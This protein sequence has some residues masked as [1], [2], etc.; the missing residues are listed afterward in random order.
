[1]PVA[2]VLAAI[3]TWGPFGAALAATGV[4]AN[5]WVSFA[6]RTA[7]G[8]GLKALSGSAA[9]VGGGAGAAR[10]YALGGVSGAALDHQIIYGRIKVGGARVY[11]ATTGEDNKFLHRI[12][13][14]AGHRIDQ[15]EDIYLNDE[16]VAK[17]LEDAHVYRFL[18]RVSETDSKGRTR[19]FW[20]SDKRVLAL[21]EIPENQ[22]SAGDYFDAPTI[23]KFLLPLAASLNVTGVRILSRVRNRETHVAAGRFKGLVRI[24]RYDGTTGQVA[25]AELID[26]TRNL[27]VQEGR[28]SNAHRL[29]GIAYL[30]VRL[31]F[32]DD[33]YP[34]GVPAISATIRGRLVHD[35]RTDT[36]AWSDNPA[37]CIRD[38]LC[39]DFGLNVPAS[40]IDDASFIAA[41]NICDQMVSGEK[42]Y[43][44]NG[45]FLTSETPENVLSAM[46]TSMGGI[47]WFSRGK[48]RVKAAA[49]S[50]PVAT[51]DE[52]DL[53]SGIQ[54]MTRSSR[55]DTFNTVKGIFSGDETDWQETD[56]PSV[57]RSTFV[58]TDGGQVNALD[59]PLPFTKT[60]SMCQRLALIALFRNREQLTFTA[61]FSTR[62]M[63]LTIGD[64]IRINN[65]RF[66]WVNKPFEI[67]S[68]QFRYEDSGELLV[69]MSL[70]EISQA[71]FESV[72]GSIFER[73]NTRLPSPFSVGP[74]AIEL[75][76]ELRVVN[77][78]VNGV[79]IAEVTAEDTNL[80]MVQVQFKKSANSIWMPV[81][82]GNPGIFE[83]LNIEDGL[84][85]VRAR[86]VNG[87]GVRGDWVYVSNFQAA[88]FAPP[89]QNVTN[90][91]GNVVGN[92]LHLTWNAVPDLDLSH[93]RIRYST[94]T[95]GALYRDAT[96][97][98]RRVARPAVSTTVPARAGTY[99][100]K[101]YDKLGTPSGASA[102]IVVRTDA[103][104]LQNLNLVS[105]LTEHDAFSGAK[106]NTVR[107]AAGT[108]Y[109]TLASGQT[110]GTY[111]FNG[112]VDLGAKYTSRAQVNANIL[113]LDLTSNFDDAPGLFDDREGLFDGDA[114]A[115][116]GTTSV[117]SQISITDDNPSG[118]PVWSDWQDFVVGDVAARA[119]RFR[120]VLESENTAHAPGVQEL[121]AVVDM[122]DRVESQQDLT[123]S[124]S[125]VLNVTFPVPF[126]EAPA[127]GLTAVLADGDRYVIT[128]RTRTGFTVTIYTG[129]VVST[130]GATVDYIAKGYG[131]G[132]A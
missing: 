64:I 87:L 10:G 88:P 119:I 83:L 54:L 75:S 81:Q 132:L 98:V 65:T 118:S 117:R 15:F 97:L 72:G 12:M 68:W 48:W 53:R 99:F 27:S 92:T 11:D 130:K 115:E 106:S 57:T 56:Y 127:I 69:D 49:W 91:A 18:Y 47:L 61:S 82:A 94:K 79:L 25:D 116:I 93:Y 3:A 128:G 86:G 28:W 114:N 73:N 107:I 89:P 52:D 41:A 1:M 16:A 38:Y 4:F 77:E 110:S 40:R 104:E 95:S 85:D 31:E 19:R 60:A 105:T 78:Q 63:T 122:P 113:F 36:T 96:D 6:V 50:E 111:T 13:A 124:S 9:R 58:T 43:T 51:F 35:P 42:R 84:Y 125:G 112:V 108:P 70:R 26:D 23:T 44:L 37:L 74:V 8:L 20:E 33:A 22:Y 67:V 76:D 24:R 66:G 121:T 100:I 14:F 17:D 30:Y 39:A 62:A 129:N 123:I 46:L 80:A 34:N 55:R 131:R 2:A 90:F 21:P 29:Q 5:M 109:L 101:A 32:D 120:I 103:G 126:K 59:L 71:A 102:S 7:I 45:A